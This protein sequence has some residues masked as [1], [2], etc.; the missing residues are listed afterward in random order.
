MLTCDAHYLKH[1]DQ[2][3]HEIL[4]CV[5]TG[6]FY[7]DKERMS[8]KE[9]ELHVTEPQEII[10]RWGKTHQKLSRILKLLLIVVGLRLN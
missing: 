4:L 6:S 1:G 9:F 3:A 10:K 8:L 2:E 5:Q 7:N